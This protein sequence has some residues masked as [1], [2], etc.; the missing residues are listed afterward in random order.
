MGRNNSNNYDLNRNFPDQ[1]VHVTDPPQPET[2]AV[3]AWLKSYPFV[4]S[5]NLHGGTTSKPS[6]FLCAGLCGV[7]VF[8]D[9][10]TVF[11]GVHWGALV[12][13]DGAKTGNKG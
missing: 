10:S 13:Q 3:M 12:L 1:F 5:A 8:R 11:L 9:I 2:R 7:G 6:S 4:L